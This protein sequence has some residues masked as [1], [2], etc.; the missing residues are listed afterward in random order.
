MSTELKTDCNNKQQI[1]KQ[2]PLSPPPPSAYTYTYT[3]LRITLTHSKLQ[4]HVH[5]NQ[6]HCVSFV[7]TKILYHKY[8][9]NIILLF[10]ILI[11]SGT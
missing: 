1:T 7:H 10:C 11:K 2:H 3:N 9:R 6:A 4:T 5:H 8:Q